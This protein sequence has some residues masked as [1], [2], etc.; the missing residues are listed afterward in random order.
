MSTFI[1]I[2]MKSYWLLVTKRIE[3]K[4][5]VDSL[6]PKY[7]AEVC[8]NRKYNKSI[9]SVKDACMGSELISLFRRKMVPDGSVEEYIKDESVLAKLNKFYEKHRLK[10]IK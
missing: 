3:K 1:P 7:V 10:S 4:L 5:D 2:N 6:D 9:G 8:R